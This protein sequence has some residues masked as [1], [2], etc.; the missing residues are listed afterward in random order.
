MPNNEAIAYY[1]SGEDLT[2][3]ANGGSVTG[4]RF[5][6][7]N[8]A[9]RVG[10]QALSTDALGGNIPI[11]LCTAGGRALGVISYDAA[12]GE[13]V[14]VMRGHKVVPVESGAALTAGNKVM[15]DATG[16]AIAWTSAAS[17]ANNALGVVLNSPSAAAQTA[18][19]A[20][21]L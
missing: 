2:C 3:Y 5:G 17:E 9:K 7:I 11:G 18:I 12:T 16:R 21:D 20:L 6:I 10:S 15:S 4:K 13:Q 14:P 1:D 19:V 8:G